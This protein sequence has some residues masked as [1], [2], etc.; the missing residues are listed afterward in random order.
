MKSANTFIVV[1]CVLT[2]YNSCRKD[3]VQQMHPEKIPLTNEQLTILAECDDTTAFKS[4]V[5]LQ[6][7]EYLKNCY[8]CSA[9]KQVPGLGEISWVGNCQ[10]R[11]VWDTVLVFSFT[12]YQPYFEELWRR[13]ELFFHIT[14]VDIGAFAIFDNSQWQQ[15]QSLSYGSYNRST[16]DGDVFDGSWGADSLCNNFFEITRL[17]LEDKEVEGKFELHLKMKAQ[18]TNGVLYSERINFLNGIFKAEIED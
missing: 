3:I 5:D 15:N 2:L 14:P 7:L 12:T 8:S 1:L 17:N 9:I 13:E 4:N 18:G 16:A 10:V 11:I 6:P